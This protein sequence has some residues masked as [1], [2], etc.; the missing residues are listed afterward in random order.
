MT[1]QP[2]KRQVGSA[3]YRESE[4]GREHHRIRTIFLANGFTIKD[5]QTD[6]KP[7]VYTE[8]RDA[9]SALLAKRGGA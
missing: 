4:E 1:K 8:W 9:A 2:Q 6:L 5:G 7:Y 3:G